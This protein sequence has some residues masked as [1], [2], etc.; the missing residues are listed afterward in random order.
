VTVDTPLSPRE[1]RF[2][3]LMLT[4]PNQTA[5]AMGAGYS[6]RTAASQ[7]SRL[8]KKVNVAA[9]LDRMRAERSQRTQSDA[10]K[11][12]RELEGIG[13]VDPIDVFYQP[14][15]A[16]EQRPLQLKPIAE[17]PV[18]A[19]RAIAAI[20]V[21]HYEA[22][23]GQNGVVYEE[24]YDVMEIKFWNKVEVLR[25]LGTHHGLRFSRTELTGKDGQPLQS[26]PTAPQVF[27]IGGQRV[28][29]Q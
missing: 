9:A 3:E 8:L 5:A 28:E 21:K 23:T 7:A 11:V 14:G 13:Y 24:P 26:A 1:Q 2:V 25:M 10:D 16:E 12:I 15:K 17:W 18:E 20:K 29:F 22:K 19:R 4:D 27:L 6:A